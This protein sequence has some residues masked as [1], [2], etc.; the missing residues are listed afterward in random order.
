MAGV[1]SFEDRAALNYLLSR[2]DVDAGCI[3]CIGIWGG[4]NRAALLTATHDNI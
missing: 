1:V 3:G 2:T 4:G